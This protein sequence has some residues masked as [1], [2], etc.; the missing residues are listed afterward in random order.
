MSRNR[1]RDL[2]RCLHFCNN[3]NPSNDRM[4]KIKNPLLHCRNKF[5]NCITP[6]QNLCIDESLLL[7][8]GRL[9]FKQ[10]IPSKR[11]RFGI[12]MFVLC[13]CTTGVVLDFIVYTGTTTD[14]ELSK[15]IGISGSIVK[16][17]L[18]PYIGKGHTL[19]VD[20]W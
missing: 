11:N 12:K 20:N 13:D 8:K 6:Y 1:F 19:Y 9:S 3:E 15:E 14:I 4:R 2:M 16:T 10:Y 17:L 18:K 7:W 5:K